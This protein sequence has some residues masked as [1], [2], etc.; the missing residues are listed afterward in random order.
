MSTLF[1]G[2]GKVFFKNLPSPLFYSFLGKAFAA[3]L[4]AFPFPFFLKYC[5]SLSRDILAA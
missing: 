5:F 2:L 1:Y 4:H 3:N